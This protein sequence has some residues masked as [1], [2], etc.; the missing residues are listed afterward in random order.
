MI[1]AWIESIAFWAIL[2]IFLALR[3]PYGEFAMGGKYKI[4]PKQMRV[5]CAVSVLIQMIA[6]LVLLQTGNVISNGL[7]Q[8]VVKGVCYFFAV[9][10][11]INTVMNSLSKSKKRRL[12]L[13]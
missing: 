7:P 1:T 6:I 13:Q 12:C 2:Y 8:G 4:M 10:L 11:I 9:Y 5:A 3:L